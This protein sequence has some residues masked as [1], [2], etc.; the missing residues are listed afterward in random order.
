MLKYLLA[1]NGLGF[2]IT[3]LDKQS[4]V[5]HRWRIPEIILLAA[6]IVG[7]SLGVLLAML[8]CHH[9]TQKPRFA[10]GIPLLLLFQCLCCFLILK[11]SHA[12]FVL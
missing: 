3:A 6:A 5:R 7:G 1:L 2:A 10:V 8:F 11:Y 4:A 12:F 9:K